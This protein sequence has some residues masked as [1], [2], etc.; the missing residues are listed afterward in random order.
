MLPSA[1]QGAGMSIE[2]GVC[3]AELLARITDRSQ[4]PRAL[5]AYQEL[6]LPRCTFVVES[7]RQNSAKWHKEDAKGGTVSD[8]IWEYDIIKE[9]REVE[10]EEA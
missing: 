3:V 2:D 4:I 10:I 8:K 9:S 7:G 1:A 5:K 6:R